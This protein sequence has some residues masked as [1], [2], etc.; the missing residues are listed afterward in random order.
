LDFGKLLT[1]LF[2]KSLMLVKL[3]VEDRLLFILFNELLSLSCIFDDKF[4]CEVVLLNLRFEVDLFLCSLNDLL[5]IWLFK[6]FISFLKV[7]IELRSTE[8]EVDRLGFSE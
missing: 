7:S 3:P 8:F 1:D 5:K 6:C 4:N 2:D